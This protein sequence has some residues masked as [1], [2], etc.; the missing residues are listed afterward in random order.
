MLVAALRRN[1]RVSLVSLA[2]TIGLSRSSTHE[3]ILRL[4]E[5]G[6][7]QGYTV[8]TNVSTANGAAAFIALRFE[9]GVD[10]RAVAAEV[11]QRRGVVAAYCLT[12]ELDMLVHVECEHIEALAE[13]RSAL[14]EAPGVAELR[15]HTVLETRRPPAPADLD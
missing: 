2:K 10:T 3:R 15:T 13:L 5:R 8:L 12:G 9:P 1:A 14:A 7:I 6:V 11:V 4:E